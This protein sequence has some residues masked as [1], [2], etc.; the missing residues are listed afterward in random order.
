MSSV[1]AAATSY[2][3]QLA[4]SVLPDDSFV[5]LRKS[6]AQMVFSAPLT[7]Q[8]YG[9]KGSQIPAELSP[10]ARREE[11]FD[12]DCCVSSYQGDDD[13][14]ARMA[15]AQTAWALLSVAVGND[16]TFGNIVRWAQI[17]DYDFIPSSDTTGKTLGSVEFKV[18]CQ[19]RIDS[20][21]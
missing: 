20:L 15:E 10:Q 8:V 13:L 2:F 1:A 21:T 9:F 18:N 11:T 17:T 3:L 19:Q 12:I 6:G 7:L 5:V 14:E 16:Y 4:R